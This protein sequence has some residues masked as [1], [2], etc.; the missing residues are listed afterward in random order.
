M[1]TQDCSGTIT[2]DEVLRAEDARFKAQIDN[3]FAAMARLYG[4]DLVYI[5][6]STVVDTKASFIESM[7]SGAVK[8]RKMSRSDV[9]VR[10]Y[11]CIG[12]LTGRAAFE[13][14]ARGQ[15][16]VRAV[17][18]GIGHDEQADT[19][20]GRLAGGLERIDDACEQVR[21]VVRADQDGEAVGG[22]GDLHSRPP[23]STARAIE[24][25]SRPRPTGAHAKARARSA[26]AAPRSPS[27]Q[28]HLA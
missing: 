8:Y 23:A 6:S 27:R 1:S 2:E 15:E 21:A 10:T 18:A 24:A 4:D 26:S 11:G 25:I 9:T 14:T 5:H 17:G 28:A 7:R 16:L 12:I 3:D 20:A 13:V 22:G 19:P